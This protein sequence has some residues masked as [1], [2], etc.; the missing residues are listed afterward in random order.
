MD[1][2]GL[3]AAVV[4]LVVYPGGLFALLAGIVVGLVGGQRPS[5]GTTSDRGAALGA[6]LVLVAAAMLPLPGSP[7][8]AI[9]EGGAPSNL[10]ALLVLLGVGTAL[11]GDHATEAAS[12]RERPAGRG[13][14]A[15]TEGRL[16]LAAAG[17]AALPVLGLAMGAASIASGVVAGLPGTRLVVARALTAAVLVLCAPLVGARTRGAGRGG[18]AIAEGVCLLLAAAVAEPQRLTAAPGVASAAY[19]LAVVAGGATLGLAVRRARL[20]AL[21]C[22]AS[23]GLTATLLA[24]IGA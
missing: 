5:L 13:P 7:A 4:A 14:G 16:Q 11:L 24:L 9:P 23:L 8:G 20:P 1:R 10:L 2:L 19:A 17:A 21:A 18:R 15:A 6:L 12:T 3:L 22:A